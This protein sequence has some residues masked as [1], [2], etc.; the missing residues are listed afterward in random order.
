MKFASSSETPKEP[1]PLGSPPG[2]FFFLALEAGLKNKAA[3]DFPDR[4]CFARGKKRAGPQEDQLQIRQSKGTISRDP[5]QAPRSSGS[6]TPVSSL[7]EIFSG[8]YPGLVAPALSR[9]PIG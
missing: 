3:P 8:L 2:G 1:S 7:R 6:A 5:W 9:A 4:S